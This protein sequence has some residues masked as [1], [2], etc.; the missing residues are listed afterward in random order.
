MLYITGLENRAH[1][2]KMAEDHISR[3][4]KQVALD[5][6]QALFSARHLVE[7][8]A[9]LPQVFLNKGKEC[10]AVVTRAKTIYPLIASVG[11][12]KPNGDVFCSAI[13]FD[14]GLS[15]ANSSWFKEALKNRGYAISRYHM[16]GLS[17]KPIMTLAYPSFNTGGK[18][19]AIVF[20]SIDL[21]WLNQIITLEQ[22]PPGYVLTIIDPQG[23]V[24]AR[25]PD[26]KFWV[27]DNHRDVPVIREI[28]AGKQVGTFQS[29]GLDGKEALFA[30]QPLQVDTG[31]S[32]AYAYVGIRNDVAYAEFDKILYRNLFGLISVIFVALLV[33]SWGSDLIVLRRLRELVSATRKLATGDLSIRTNIA[34]KG[35]VGQL[36]SAIDDMADALE[37]ESKK[38]R[39]SRNQLQASQSMLSTILNS[40]PVRVFWKDKKLNYIGCNEL[41]AKDVDLETPYQVIGKNDFDFPWADQAEKYRA[42]DLDVI[43]SGTPKLL[44]EVVQTDSNG[45]ERWLEVSK[46]PL[47]DL[48]EQ[49]IG[50]LG[51]Y[52][53][54]TPR[55]ST[56]K[57]LNHM[58]YH[59]GLTGLINRR[60]FEN[61]LRHI[62]EKTRLEDQEHALLY[63]D[64]DQFKIIN[65]TSGHFAG[66]E[67]LKQLANVL[68][69]SVRNN[70]VLARLGG[71]EFGVILENCQSE[72]ALVIAEEILSNVQSFKFIWKAK[73]FSVGASIGLI[74][75]DASAPNM[76][77]LLSR[78]D[79]ACYAAK[80]LG[81]N[82]VHVYEENNLDLQRRH[83]E[84]RWVGR[85]NNAFELEQ[86]RLYYQDI[87]PLQ[88]TAALPHREILLRMINDDGSVVLP[89]AFIAAAERYGLMQRI[90]QWVIST[91]INWLEK[92]RQQN[93]VLDFERVFINLS[94]TSLG[95][96]SFLNFIREKIRKVA[97]LTRYLGFEITETSAIADF[98]HA[99][100]FISEIK[101][102]GCQVAL[103]DFGAGMS[104]FSYLRS[105]PVDFIKI[106]GSFVRTMLDDPMDM[107][108]VRSINQVGHVANIRT[109]AEYVESAEVERALAGMGIDYAQG[110]RIS[111]AKPL[112][113]LPG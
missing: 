44:Y 110:F 82:R 112:D 25:T 30:F 40:I 63:I 61:R 107:A 87:V 34:S 72:R 68:S 49:V 27:G 54:I 84:M 108:I 55:K 16:G 64:L 85:I 98:S 77:E 12:I 109:I 102:A 41:F 32:M 6:K 92:S 74:V 37:K 70:D 2:K 4:V 90:D 38:T 111:K 69:G 51:I 48:N 45:N 101:K 56:E 35:E 57:K 43:T 36:A 33:A 94:G 46:I 79:M 67:L 14:A 21:K 17:K 80:D 71:D 75:L 8:I 29:R 18:L 52:Q 91:V 83:G 60:E 73:T 53:D 20:V 26:P 89:A 106:D 104:S 113:D 23:T 78:A 50:V 96:E 47:Q 100:K 9:Q 15:A 3:L 13:P 62:L 86:F 97:H 88:D 95:D 11:A 103:D 39:E 59:D 1:A 58:A 19:A 5:Q 31:I 99:E 22:L 105:L 65:D 7:T 10:D 24:L 76:Q 81:R 42:N 66:D 28:L 93:E